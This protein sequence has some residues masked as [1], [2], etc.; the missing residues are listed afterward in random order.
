MTEFVRILYG[1]VVRRKYR[2]KFD[3][4]VTKTLRSPCLILGNH[5]TPLDP[6]CMGLGFR[7]PINYVA[8]GAI[9]RL[10]FA[11]RLIDLIIAPIPKAK[12]VSDPSAVMKILSVLKRGGSVGIFPEGNRTYN[13]ESVHVPPGLGKLCKRLTCPIIVVRIERGYFTAPRWGRRVRRGQMRARLERVLTPEDT[14]AMTAE[15]LDGVLRDALYYDAYEHQRRDPVLFKDKKRAEYIQRAL[16][17]CPDCRGTGTIASENERFHCTDCGMEM[18]YGEDG[19]LIPI[20]ASH[21]F[22]TVLEWDRWQIGHI[23][24][25]DFSALPAGEPVL[26]DKGATLYDNSREGR[27]AKILKGGMVSL[28]KDR[29]VLEGHGKRGRPPL[30]EFALA[31]M[32]SATVEGMAKVGFYLRDGRAFMFKLPPDVSPYKYVVHIY[33]LQSELEQKEMTYYGI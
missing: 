3:D 33:K 22:T 31:D 9:K 10:K 26:R 24:Q 1:P 12:G 32:A 15:Q 19:F 18:E 14:A 13:G 29:L 23:K 27:R 4:S 20:K 6:F 30:V 5:A 8:S 16:F 7:F 11:G 28:Y 21:A 25:K 2:F 17:V